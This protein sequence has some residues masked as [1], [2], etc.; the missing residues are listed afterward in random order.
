MSKFVPTKRN[1]RE[2]LLFCF[3]LKKSVA[4][5]QRML[6]EAYGDYAPSISTCEYWFRRYKKGD[7]DTEDKERPGQPKKFGDEELEALL[8][9]D[10]SQTQ[11]ELAESLIVDRSTISRRLKAIGMIQKQ[12]N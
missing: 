1:L 4:E 10:P 12:G 11:E 2:A 6:S 5:S 9:Q 3:H 8:D 7:F